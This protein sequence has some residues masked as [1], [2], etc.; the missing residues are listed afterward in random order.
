MAATTIFGYI[1][2]DRTETRGSGFTVGDKVESGIYTIMFNST[3]DG[4]PAFSDIPVFVANCLENQTDRGISIHIT[5]IDNTQ[6]QIAVMNTS[7]QTPYDIA[8]NFIV[9]GTVDD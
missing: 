5:Q 4:T 7:N 3:S 9:M 1:S 2:A 6:V 8:F